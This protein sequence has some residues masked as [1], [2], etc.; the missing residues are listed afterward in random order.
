VWQLSKIEEKKLANARKQYQSLCDFCYTKHKAT[1]DS[2][3]NKKAYSLAKSEYTQALRYKHSDTYIASQMGKIEKLEKDEQYRQLMKTG[4]EAL[5]S[6]ATPEA[7]T[8]SRDALK[9]G[10][11]DVQ[12]KKEPSGGAN[13]NS[14]L[15]KK[16][17]T[18]NENITSLSEYRDT[19]AIAD[20]FFQAG[21]YEAAKKTYKK[22]EA[23]KPGEPYTR[24][25]IAEIDSVL[26]AR[27]QLLDR[28]KRDSA[29]AALSA[30]TISKT[31]KT[32]NAGDVKTAKSASR[33]AQPEKQTERTEKFKEAFKVYRKADE[34]RLE[35]KYPEAY[36]GFS[37][38][39][40]HLDT[41]NASLYQISERYYIDQAKEYIQQLESNSPQ[42]L[43]SLKETPLEDKRKRRNIKND[44]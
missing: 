22:A 41:A 25:R 42:H 5:T 2:A 10:I 14:E 27:K 32:G 4:K 43:G 7:T 15:V 8:A 26:I 6:S 38:F 12:A 16:E 17:Q 24:K 36:N 44:K 1:G 37:T 21:L 13:K 18:A 23:L 40:N 34:A 19:L 3:F 9:P 20:Q 11:N 39:L 35:R 30:N 31:D 33:A 28:R 29:N